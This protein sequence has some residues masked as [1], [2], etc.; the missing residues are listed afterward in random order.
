ML[1]SLICS[2]HS[3]LL[4]LPHAGHGSPTL[5]SL[6]GGGEGQ[7]LPQEGARGGQARRTVARGRLQALPTVK[8][9]LGSPLGSGSGALAP[10]PSCSTPPPIRKASGPLPSSLPTWEPPV[11]D[12]GRHFC[13]SRVMMPVDA[14]GA[15]LC[16]DPPPPPML[17]PGTQGGTALVG[18]GPVPHPSRAGPEP[19]HECSPA[20][21]PQQWQPAPGGGGSV[22]R[23]PHGLRDTA[24][25]SP[26]LQLASQTMPCLP[27]SPKTPRPARV[28]SPASSQVCFWGLRVRLLGARHT[29]AGVPWVPG[30]MSPPGQLQ[31]WGRL[32]VCGPPQADGGRG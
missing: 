15:H 10:T 5:A 13:R 29:A 24:A 25:W 20:L 1:K 3:C 18:L 17:M 11:A 9:Y 22:V 8:A 4:H 14:V 23:A 31:T 2:S 6:G 19:R 32:S 27:V 30:G 21:G 16:L 12:L 26:S 7:R 28:C